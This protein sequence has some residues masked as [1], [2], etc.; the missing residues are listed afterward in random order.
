MKLVQWLCIYLFDMIKFE[1]IISKIIFYLNGS[2]FL[3]KFNKFKLLLIDTF[4]NRSIVLT[5]A[6]CKGRNILTVIEKFN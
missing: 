4:K 2:L 6:G 3:V 1:N 5:F